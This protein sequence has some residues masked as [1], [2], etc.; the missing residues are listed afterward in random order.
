MRWLFVAALLAGGLMRGAGRAVVGVPSL[1]LRGDYLAI[2]TLGFGEIIRVIILNIEITRR[3]A[4]PHRHS[5][6]HN[7]S[8][9]RRRRRSR[10]YVVTTW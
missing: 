8:G 7:F 10:S 2:V 9:L 3:R 6:L 1:R 4:R 5:R